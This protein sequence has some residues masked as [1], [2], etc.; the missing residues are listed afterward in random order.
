MP[1][2]IDS[3]LIS[4]LPDRAHPASQRAGRCR[5]EY[6][7]PHIHIMGRSGWKFTLSG[8]VHSIE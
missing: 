2:D 1:S 4:H 5:D 6:S 8:E 3:R 7:V